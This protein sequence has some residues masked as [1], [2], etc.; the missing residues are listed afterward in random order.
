MTKLRNGLGTT[1]PDIGGLKILEVHDYSWEYNG[2]PKSNVLKC[3]IEGG[4][5]VVIRPSGTE[6]KIK[7]YVSVVGKE[8]ES[9]ELIEEKATISLLD[10]LK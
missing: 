3:I 4:S 9:L 5:S 2:L 1:I 7:V 10:Y 8:K 6:P